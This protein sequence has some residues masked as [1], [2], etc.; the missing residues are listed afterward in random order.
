MGCA[1]TEEDATKASPLGF[2][3]GR[4]WVYFDGVS[5]RVGQSLFFLQ[6]HGQPEPPKRRAAPSHKARGES[7]K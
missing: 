4:L 3:E 5:A 2:S 6:A 7:V 1:E